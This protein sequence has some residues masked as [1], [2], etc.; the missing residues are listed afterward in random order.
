MTT[1]ISHTNCEFG[2]HAIECPEHAILD[3][4]LTVGSITRHMVLIYLFGA[5]RE[6]ANPAQLEEL[7]TLPDKL[8]ETDVGLAEIGT[9]IFTL[10]GNTWVPSQKWQDA[11]DSLTGKKT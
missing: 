3:S 1:C 11:I 5:A 10:M 2:L 9:A 6:D 4:G 7:R 8:R